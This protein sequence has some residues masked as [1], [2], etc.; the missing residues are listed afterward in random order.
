MT[1]QAAEKRIE[2]MQAEIERLQ[3]AQRFILKI[4]T[5]SVRQA[6]AE[7]RQARQERDLCINQA[8]AALKPLALLAV[9]PEGPI[10][11]LNTGEEVTM[12]DIERAVRFV[13]LWRR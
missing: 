1:E 6:E 13:S 9:P 10:A 4:S 11:H 3:N 7:L 8:C 2:W 5:Q 12:D